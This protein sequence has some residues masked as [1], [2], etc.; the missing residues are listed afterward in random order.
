M[1]L[2]YSSLYSRDLFVPALMYS[3]FVDIETIQIRSHEDDNESGG[4]AKRRS[5]Q[6]RVVMMVGGVELDMRGRCSTGQK[7]K[8]A[9]LILKVGVMGGSTLASLQV[10]VPGRG[11][12]CVMM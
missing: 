4:M 5:Y 12:P 7:V 10:A 3:L 8:L 2:A 6:Y 1:P 11:S 9:C